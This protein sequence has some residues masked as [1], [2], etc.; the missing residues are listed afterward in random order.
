MLPNGEYAWQAITTAYQAESGERDLCDT[1]DLKKHWHKVLCNCG[2][3]PLGKPGAINNCIFCCIAIKQHIL[4][5]TSSG[6]KGTL[7][8][9][10]EN[11]LGVSLT[12]DSEDDDDDD[13]DDGYCP[14]SCAE[15]GAKGV[16]ANDDCSTESVAS[17]FVAGNDLVG[18][19]VVFAASV[20]PPV[21]P[22]VQNE[23]EAAIDGAPLEDPADSF[24]GASANEGE[25]HAPASCPLLHGLTTSHGSSA[26]RRAP[27]TREVGSLLTSSQKSKNSNNKN[28]DRTNVAGAIV[29]LCESF[30]DRGAARNDNSTREM[31]NADEY[32]GG[33]N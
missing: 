20:L 19:N 1:T 4:E 11:N 21:P 14:K 7:S 27:K 25:P 2:K 26:S 12:E 24:D 23:V 15:G 30:K 8:I 31:M 16:A 6:M 28:K 33:L 32:D 5:K 9:E 3:N 18:G 22:S 10:D 13:K 17:G 29:E